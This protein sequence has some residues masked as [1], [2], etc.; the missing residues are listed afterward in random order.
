MTQQTTTPEG[1]A[2]TPSTNGTTATPVEKTDLAS[3]PADV[4]EYI[5][6]LRSEAKKH[7]LEKSDAEK[8]RQREEAARL[9]ADKQWEALANKYKDEIDA[10]RPRAERVDAMEQFI[11]EMAQKRLDALP[12]QYRSLD[13]KY[14]DPLKTLQW[15]DA[16]AATFALPAVPNLGAG[17]QG[18]SAGQAAAKLTPEELALAQRAGMTPEQFAQYKTRTKPEGA[19]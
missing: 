14:D 13:P 12:K 17:Q 1:A 9:E 4:R 11:A 16:N 10:M 15:L 5:E 8:A 18:D 19:R 2:E 7:R 3:L 6:S